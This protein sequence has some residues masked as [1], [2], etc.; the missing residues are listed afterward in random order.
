MSPQLQ[1][2]CGTCANEH[3]PLI[4]PNKFRE[5]AGL[6]LGQ[7]FSL[8]L[9]VRGL[10]LRRRFRRQPAPLAITPRHP[11]RPNALLLQQADEG[12]SHQPEPLCSELPEV[13]LPAFDWT[14]G[15]AVGVERRADQAG[16]ASGSE[17]TWFYLLVQ[18]VSCHSVHGS[19]EHGASRG[20]SV[21]PARHPRLD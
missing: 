20:G 15:P 7:T 5:R 21:P 11:Y 19:R 12:G 6:G 17:S 16:G 4:C 2:R 3:R 13:R 18:H 10:E 9:V 14:T 1:D 8:A